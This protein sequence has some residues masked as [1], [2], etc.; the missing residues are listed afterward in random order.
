MTECTSFFSFLLLLVF[1]AH[2]SITHHRLKDV[3]FP[4]PSLHRVCL[5]FKRLRVQRR[6]QRYLLR[7]FILFSATLFDYGL[8]SLRRTPENISSLI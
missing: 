3:V 2:T 4:L 7:V 6:L 8:D 5:C 1:V